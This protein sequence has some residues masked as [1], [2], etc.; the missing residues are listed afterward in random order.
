MNNN[1]ARPRAGVVLTTLIKIIF[2]VALTY[3]PAGAAGFIVK[4]VSR[5]PLRW[6]L[7]MMLEPMLKRAMGA[8]VGQFAKEKHETTAK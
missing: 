5:K 2:S 4:N 3:G 8:A 7:L 6:L 1:S